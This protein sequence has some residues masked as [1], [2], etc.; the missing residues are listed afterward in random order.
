MVGAGKGIGEGDHVGIWVGEFDIVGKC[1]GVLL[2]YKF[3]VH[4]T[5]L[6]GAVPDV[7]TN[8]LSYITKREEDI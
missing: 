4:S 6:L 8:F 7:V 5:L 1:E 2:K 3:S